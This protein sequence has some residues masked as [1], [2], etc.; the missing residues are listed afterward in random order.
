MVSAFAD[1]TFTFETDPTFSFVMI[2]RWTINVRQMEREDTKQSQLNNT[3]TRNI[4]GGKNSMFSRNIFGGTR[5]LNIDIVKPSMKTK[6][7][8]PKN[9]GGWLDSDSQ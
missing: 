3:T 2:L 1:T 4:H 8:P 6:S 9:I 5:D 7:P